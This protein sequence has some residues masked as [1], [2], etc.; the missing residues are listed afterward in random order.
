MPSMKGD[1][2]SPVPMQPGTM[3]T[4]TWAVKEEFEMEEPTV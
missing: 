2:P 3:S 1:A 4:N